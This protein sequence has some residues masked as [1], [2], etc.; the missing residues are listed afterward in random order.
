MVID[1]WVR[2]LGGVTKT[3][4]LTLLLSVFSLEG[5]KGIV[6][7]VKQVSFSSA[8]NSSSINNP[9]ILRQVVQYCWSTENF[10]EPTGQTPQL[11]SLNHSTPNRLSG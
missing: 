7:L 5:M 4:I 3:D 2:G 9:N 10:P 1:G 6:C 8:S 11:I